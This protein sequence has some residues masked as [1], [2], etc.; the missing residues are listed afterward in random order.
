MKRLVVCLDG[1]WNDAD[2]GKA[3]TN[4]ARLARAIRA[5]TNTHGVP[6][7]VLYLRGVGTSGLTAERVIAGATGLGIDDNIRSAYMFLAQNYVPRDNATGYQGDEIHLFGF[8]RGAFSARSLSGFIGA[9]GLLKRQKLGDLGKAWDYYRKPGIRNPDD[10]MAM[11]GSESHRGVTIRFL[12]VWDTVGALGIPSFLFSGISAKMYGFHDT[13]P[14]KI[15]RHGAHALA[16]DEH[17]DEFIP[18]LWTGQAPV[19]STIEQVWFAGAHSDVGGGYVDGRLADIPLLWM[20]SRAASTGLVFDPSVLPQTLEPL[21]PLHESRQGFSAKDRFTPTI[22]RVCERDINV[23]FYE[24]LYAP[25]DEAGKALATINEGIHDSLARRWRQIGRLSD[26]DAAQTS[27][28]MGYAPR[29]LSPLF[30]PDGQTR[31]GI[32]VFSTDPIPV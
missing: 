32:Q 7:L 3:D 26:D 13:S 1:T 18:T 25:R 2:S 29:N 9:C 15:V 21:A 20:A 17:R 31:Q 6:Q 28:D 22:R 30:R 19:G 5:T 27:V 11:T 8:S 23:A 14:S 10:F 12:G 4:V 24:R 16:V